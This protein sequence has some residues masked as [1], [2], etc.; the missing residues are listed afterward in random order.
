MHSS[1]SVFNILHVFTGI[2]LAGMEEMEG[3]KKMEG[4]KRMEGMETGMIPISTFPK[5]TWTMKNMGN[6]II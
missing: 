2:F 1:L 4:M 5:S 6:F 3:M